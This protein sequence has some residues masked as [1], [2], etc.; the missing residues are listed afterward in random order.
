MAVNVVIKN[1]RFKTGAPYRTDKLVLEVFWKT[2]L[3]W[4]V[5]TEFGLVF[6]C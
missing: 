6:S 4:S 3:F 2:S 1:V 5:F